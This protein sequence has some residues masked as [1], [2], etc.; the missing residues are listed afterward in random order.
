ME[1]SLFLLQF[2]PGGYFKQDNP[3]EGVL[4]IVFVSVV[5]AAIILYQIVR[6][7]RGSG[8]GDASTSS[9]YGFL[10]IRRLASEYGLDTEQRKLLEYVFKNTG[11]G[12]PVRIMNSSMLLDRHFK[13]AYNLIEKNS[14]T[15]EILQQRLIKLFSLRNA[16]DAAPV[17][18]GQSYGQIAANT[19]AVLIVDEESYPVR[20]ISTQN[21]TIIT[22]IPRNALGNP[23]KLTRGGKI[24]LSFFTKSSKGFSYDG[25]IAGA[26]RTDHGPALQIIHSGIAKPLVKRKYRRKETTIRCEFFLVY[27]DS[28]GSGRKNVQ[29]LVVDKKRYTGSVQDI[30]IGGC[31]IKTIAPIQVGSR[32]KIGIDHDS[33]FEIAVLGQVLRSNRSITGTIIHIKFLKVPRRAFNS[34]SAMVF[35]Y[36]DE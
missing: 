22:E 23:V 5:I 36:E 1:L 17:K 33:N 34:I 11:V 25:K 9:S 31:S 19:P 27:E 4:I 21:Q 6:R 28:A 2:I 32:L 7:L 24:S 35:G 26:L 10:T 15:E 12:D 20:V 8:S 29:K 14:E 3:M 16:I 30:S 13:R 18:E